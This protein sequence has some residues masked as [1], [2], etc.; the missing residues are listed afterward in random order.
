MFFKKSF[1]TLVSIVT[2]MFFLY[3]PVLWAKDKETP[4]DDGQLPTFTGS[5]QYVSF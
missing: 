1:V 3:T 5:V 4:P 2:I